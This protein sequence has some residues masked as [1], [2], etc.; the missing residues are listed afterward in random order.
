MT[1]MQRCDQAVD[2]SDWRRDQEFAEYPEGARD[3]TLLY[4]PSPA[5]VSWI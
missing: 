1:I 3:K 5:T 4:C 2:I